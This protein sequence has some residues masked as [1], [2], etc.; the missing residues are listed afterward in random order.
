[1]SVLLL[2]LLFVLS[3]QIKS[4]V[5]T[6]KIRGEVTVMLLNEHH[7]STTSD[8]QQIRKRVFLIK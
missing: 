6:G 2:L 3:L 5:Q 4:L 8:K 7:E 1:M